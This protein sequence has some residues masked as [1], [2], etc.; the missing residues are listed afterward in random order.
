[1]N[2]C[3]EKLIREMINESGEMWMAVRKRTPFGAAPII[4]CKRPGHAYYL[5]R[6]ENYQGEDLS[7]IKGWIVQEQPL[8]AHDAEGFFAAFGSHWPYWAGVTMNGVPFRAFIKNGRKDC[9]SISLDINT[10]PAEL[11]EADRS[12]ISL[13]QLRSKS[14]VREWKE[15]ERQRQRIAKA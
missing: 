11:A 7:N 10:E 15:E 3:D 5:V 1:M 4:I 13:Q 9:W 12:A 8:T 6:A 2:E 14:L